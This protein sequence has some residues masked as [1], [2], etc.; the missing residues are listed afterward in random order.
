M[1]E[2]PRTLG[3]LLAHGSGLGC[4]NTTNR[5]VAQNRPR[6]ILPLR[7]GLQITHDRSEPIGSALE[8]TP[9]RP[10]IR[11]LN[12]VERLDQIHVLAF[13]ILRGLDL[14]LRVVDR[15]GVRLDLCGTTTGTLA[16]ELFRFRRKMVVEYQL[17]DLLE[18]RRRHDG[19][20]FPLVQNR[21]R[22]IPNLTRGQPL[23]MSGQESVGTDLA[24]VR[25]PS[26]E[27]E[28]FR[29]HL[30]SCHETFLWQGY[31]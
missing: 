6:E 14:T 2:S 31:M 27:K 23:L 19:A 12:Q 10:P 18:S 7:I 1:R 13:R 30:A 4:Q 24:S 3:R 28:T 8:Q 20:S 22:D 21:L 26:L 15:R 11:L 5:L 25:L 29:T 16:C 9:I 17:L